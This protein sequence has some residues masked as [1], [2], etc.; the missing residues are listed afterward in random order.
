MATY[1]DHNSPKVDVH[2]KIPLFQHQKALVHKMI[3]MESTPH[4]DTFIGVL[5]DPPGS[6]K[7][8]PLLALM[9]HEKRTFG[10]TQNLLIIPE[11]IHQQWLEY[12]KNYSDELNARSLMYYGD[13][14]SLYYD[15]R[16]LFE[17][18]I[19]ISTSAFY[20]MIVDTVRD[21][22]TYFNRVILD[23]IDS[24]SFFT[25]AKV[26]SQSVWLVSA[27]AELTKSGVYKEAAKKNAIMCDPHFIKRSIN[28]PPP[29]MDVR[30]CYNEFVEIL[31]QNVVSPV[32][33]KMVYACDFTK[34]RFDY[35]RNE[36]I[37]NARD[38]VSAIFRDNCLAYHSTLDSI[39]TLEE[40]AK[41]QQYLQS[42]YQ[43]K[44]Q[45]REQLKKEINNLLNIH[46]RK[47]CPMCVRNFAEIDHR[48]VTKC[49]NLLLCKDCSDKW[50]EKTERCP[51]CYVK[52]LPEDIQRDHN[53]VSPVSPKSPLPD[54][55]P[56]FERILLQARQQNDSRILI[57]SDHPGSFLKVQSILKKH[58]LV[59][60]EIEGNQ[61]TMNKAI[62]E[63]RNGKK[64]I[65]LVDSQSYGAG[66]NMEC[67]SAV[68]ILHRTERQEQIIGRAQRPGRT[69]QLR[70]FHLL[71]EKE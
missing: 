11:N 55:I 9:L 39:K 21:I 65:L 13:I 61:F 22:G 59:Y 48:V 31:Q 43:K 8:F 47:R 2:A 49:C 44:I 41:Y 60:T 36:H 33:L 30:Q 14:T 40:G 29:I 17:F 4:N 3:E 68:I 37:E 64:P 34:F 46:S 57:F 27:S 25:L 63:Y 50:F 23:E 28:L 69:D 32:A 26:P 42:S 58:D 5:K 62:A 53:A 52:V 18:D 15:A 1:L 66:M 70:I 16:A 56:E 71:Y 20:A 35:L 7:S 6:G 45:K 51:S 24:I 19:L 54:K 38:L 10:K 67:T 12:I